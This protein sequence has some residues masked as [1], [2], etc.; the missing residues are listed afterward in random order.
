M[1]K[2]AFGFKKICP[3]MAVMWTTNIFVIIARGYSDDYNYNLKRT[4]TFPCADWA[5]YV[6]TTSTNM[7]LHWID[8]YPYL[9][10]NQNI[11]ESIIIAIDC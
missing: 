7:Y 9:E 10:G 6:N 1:K 5:N 4:V 2:T 11:F 3:E 8:C